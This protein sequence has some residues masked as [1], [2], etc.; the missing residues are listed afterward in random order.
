MPEKE[1]EMVMHRFFEGELSV[2][3]ST[4]IIGAGLDVPTA[5]T[6]IINMSDRMGLADLYQLRGRVGRSSRKGY[7]FFLAPP[8]S[9]LTE[10]ARKRLDAV[11]EMSYLG[12]G[13]RLALKDLEIRG[14][15]EIFGA[16]QSGHIDEVGFDLYIEMLEQAV[17]ELKGT[18]VPERPEPVIDLQAAAFIPEEYLEDVTLRL[19]F[20]RRISSL[21]TSEQADEFLSEL[22][23]RFGPPPEEVLNLIKIMRLRIL[24]RKLLVTRVQEARGRVQVLFSADTPVEPP[25]IFGLHDTRKGAVR[26][27]SEGFELDLRGADWEKVYEELQRAMTEL[28]AGCCKEETGE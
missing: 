15:G 17:A 26:F 5:N 11:Q 21:E 23:D 19:S 28:A 1:L 2:L 22:N 13:F 16:E 27:L 3:V 10:E 9:V 20:Y 6:I 4:A 7:A 14:A 24:A 8:E 12:A 25:R 18:E